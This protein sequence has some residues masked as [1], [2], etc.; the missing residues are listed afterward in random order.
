MN[1]NNE[2]RGHL[3]SWANLHGLQ[4]ASRYDEEDSLLGILIDT[5]SS[6]GLSRVSPPP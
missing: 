1:S 3:G 2:T 4:R 6:L 5:S